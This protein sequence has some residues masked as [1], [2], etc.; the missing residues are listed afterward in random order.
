MIHFQPYTEYG[1]L[2][3]SKMATGNI[4]VHISNDKLATIPIP[5]PPLEEQNRIIAKIEELLPYVDRYAE[6]CVDG[7]AFRDNIEELF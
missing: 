4:I 2:C 6:A 1:I 5:L 3:K 7:I